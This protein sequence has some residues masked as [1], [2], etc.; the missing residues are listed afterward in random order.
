VIVPTSVAAEEPEYEVLINGVPWE[1]LAD[2]MV[3]GVI[4]EATEDTT[5]TLL[6]DMALPSAIAFT[7]KNTKADGSPV[8]FTFDLNGHTVESS[9]SNAFQVGRNK[10][11][12]ANAKENVL[13]M[14]NG[15]INHNGPGSV[16]QIYSY[17]RCDLENLI[18][19]C[20]EKVKYCVINTMTGSDK[21]G[22]KMVLTVKNVESTLPTKCSTSQTSFFRTGNPAEHIDLVYAVR[23]RLSDTPKGV[24]FNFNGGAFEDR[25]GLRASHRAHF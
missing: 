8:V 5:I 18:I 17:G 11:N 15:I 21:T 14:K 3:F 25:E 2:A 10:D 1:S 12:A 23:S 22:L 6:K 7:S 24:H 9:A 20:T 16:V 13:I 19:N 4:D